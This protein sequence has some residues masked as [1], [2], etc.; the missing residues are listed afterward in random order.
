MKNIETTNI[1]G[2][3]DAPFVKDTFDHYNESI[4]DTTSN[5]V[6][7]LLKSY[8]TNDIIILHGCVVSATIPGT[9]SIT[10]GA[11]YYNGE[12]YEVDANASLITSGLQ[13]LVWGI[14]TTYRGSDPLTWS[15]GIDRN[16]HRINKMALSAGLSGSGL[17][18]YDASTVKR[19]NRPNT[20]FDAFSGTQAMTNSFVVVSGLTFTTPNDGITR[21]YDITAEIASRI[22]LNTTDPAWE[23]RLYNTT[24]AGS[25]ITIPINWDEPTGSVD[26]FIIN[27]QNSVIYGGEIGANKTIELQIRYTTSTTTMDVKSGSLRATEIYRA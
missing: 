23:I 26:S 19:Y 5:I 18:N 25:L 6:K 11:V 24:D 2:S 4:A 16:L 22:E 21:W 10:A 17:S 3:Q 9:S 27:P 8:T 12:I 13:T 14:I 15:D 20:S 7:G 1:T